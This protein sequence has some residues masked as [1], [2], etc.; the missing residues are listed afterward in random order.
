MILFITRFSSSGSG[1]VNPVVW[2]MVSTSASWWCPICPPGVIDRYGESDST[3]N[4]DATLVRLLTLTVLSGVL[5]GSF[6][7]MSVG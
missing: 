6:F 7:P 3:V 5:D 2:R 4:G 1:S